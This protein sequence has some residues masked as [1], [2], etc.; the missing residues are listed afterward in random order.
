MVCLESFEDLKMNNPFSYGVIEGF[1]GKSWSWSIRE[2]YAAFLK[3]HGFGFYIYAPKDDAYL[4]KKWRE[5]WPED[6]MQHLKSLADVYAR[7]GVSWGVGL[8][9]F[10]I[11]LNFD[12]DA[13]QA[14]KEKVLA[15]NRLKPDIV[16]VLLDDMKGD[17]PQLAE[18][19][20][21]V[22]QFIADLSTASR[23][24]LCPTYYS[25][26][27][28]LERVFGKIP[29]D[30]WDILGKQLDS[31]ADIFWTGPE[32]CSVEYPESHL[33][34]VTERLGRKPFVWDNYPVNDS[35]KKSQI[36]QLRAFENRPYQM[37]AHTAGH[38]VNPMKQGWLSQ[39]P[40]KTLCDV[41][42]LK[43]RYN[44]E[45]ALMAALFELCGADL[46]HVLG[47]DMDLFQ[48]E[49]LDA[50]DESG[51]QALIKKYNRFKSP[52][53]EEVVA[54]IQGHYAFDPACLTE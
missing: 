30:Y 35:K 10:E 28:V 22:F 29:E 40:L 9:P 19:Q 32:V 7:S 31:A 25:F 24:I 23:F 45:K 17:V 8:S 38:A 50:I 27:P 46:G 39:I 26:D 16:C 54:W 53:A 51:R 37:V 42:G 2:A 13:K 52:Y 18:T 3:S 4:R 12:G 48:D 11:Y 15:I 47:D 44:S 33:I 49:G 5:P 1:Y 43:D 34:E 36:L 21:E 6:A 14:L 20:V 41:Y